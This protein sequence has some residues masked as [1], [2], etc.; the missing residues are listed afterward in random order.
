MALALAACGTGGKVSASA[1]V[2]NGKT[3][4]QQLSQGAIRSGGFDLNGMWSPWYVQHK[5]YAGLRDAY[6]NTGNR[7]AWPSGHSR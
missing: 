3:L 5:I 4:F 6:R 1:D 7:T 2:Q